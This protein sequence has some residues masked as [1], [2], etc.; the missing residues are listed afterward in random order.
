MGLRNRRAQSMFSRCWLLIAIFVITRDASSAQDF[1]EFEESQAVY[2]DFKTLADSSLFV[3]VKAHVATLKKK[4]LTHKDC[5]DL[6]QKTCKIVEGNHKQNQK[7]FDKMSDGSECLTLGQL[8]LKRMR[9]QTL[10]ITKK[11]KRGMTKLKKIREAMVPLGTWKFKTLK[12]AKC[13][14]T[15]KG[16]KDCSQ[17]VVVFPPGTYAAYLRAKKI[18]AKARSASFKWVMMAMESEWSVKMAYEAS[19]RMQTKCLCTKKN[20]RDRLWRVLGSKAKFKKEKTEDEKCRL[21]G[22]VLNGTPVSRKNCHSQLKPLR[23]KTLIR[24]AEKTPG[25]HCHTIATKMSMKPASEAQLR[26]MLSR[27]LLKQ[28]GKVKGKKRK[29][30]T[31]KIHRYLK[32]YV[33]RRNAIKQIRLRRL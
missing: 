2:D 20:T 3:Q 22:C 14:I 31:H 18:E 13:R 23:K 26:S 33:F 1:P 5:K 12:V 16:R 19:L 15:G 24:K 8:L 7:I 30:L 32:K 6:A 25:K 21:M 10:R 4:G 27:V 17:P 9:S 28:Y 11:W 29:L